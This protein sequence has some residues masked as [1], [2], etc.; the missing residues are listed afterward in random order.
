VS[1]NTTARSYN[2]DTNQHTVTSD[3]GGSLHRCSI[4]AGGS[5]SSSSRRGRS[6]TIANPH[7]NMTGTVVVT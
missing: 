1:V 2:G 6:P 5:A 7:P 4:R 3:T